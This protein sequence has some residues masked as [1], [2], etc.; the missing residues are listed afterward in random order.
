M[1][2]LAEQLKESEDITEFLQNIFLFTTRAVV[3][4]LCEQ[5]GQDIVYKFLWF[6]NIDQAGALQSALAAVY[7][8]SARLQECSS[9]W[10]LHAH[11]VQDV[12]DRD[13][14]RCNH[15]RRGNSCK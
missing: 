8:D 10:Q 6:P 11:A 3:E 13:T 4:V 14:P 1:R 15:S 5:V 2:N 12:L 7:G 9:R